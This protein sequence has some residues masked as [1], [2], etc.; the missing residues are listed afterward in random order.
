MTYQFTFR[1]RCLIIRRSG[2]TGFETRPADSGGA[3][4]EEGPAPERPL[5]RTAETSALYRGKPRASHAHARIAL[6]PLDVKLEWQRWHSG[7]WGCREDL[8]YLLRKAQGHWHTIGEDA[9]VIV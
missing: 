3:L 5:P 8:S 6:L 4:A 2:R 1:E 7:R 9:G